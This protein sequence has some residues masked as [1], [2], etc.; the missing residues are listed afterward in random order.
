VEGPPVL[1]AAEAPAA[2]SEK[3]DP[4]EG[5]ATVFTAADTDPEETVVGPQDAEKGAADDSPARDRSGEAD[6]AAD[7]GGAGA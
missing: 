7:G 3:V 4:T 2:P 6:G 5:A 1:L